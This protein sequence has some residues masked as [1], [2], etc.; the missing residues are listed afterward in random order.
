MFGSQHKLLLLNYIFRISIQD[1]KS[2]IRGPRSLNKI[3]KAMIFSK[4][5]LRAWLEWVTIR[6][7]CSGKLWYMFEMICTATSVFPVPAY[8]SKIVKWQKLPRLSDCSDKLLVMIIQLETM[9]TTSHAIL[10]SFLKLWISF[11]LA[12]SKWFLNATIKY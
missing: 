11:S 3:T 5:W 10:Q 12:S 1:F 4:S 8:I 9:C 7:L 2:I 6:V